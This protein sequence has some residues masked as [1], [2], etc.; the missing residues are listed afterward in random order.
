MALKKKTSYQDC[1][2]LFFTEHR[3]SAQQEADH[4]PP[5]GKPVTSVTP[6]ERKAKRQS[7]LLKDSR[8]LKCRCAAAECLVPLDYLSAHMNWI[9]LYCT[10]LRKEFWGA[11]LCWKL[12]SMWGKRAGRT[13]RTEDL[14][15][16]LYRPPYWDGEGENTWGCGVH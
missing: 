5:D 7:R 10:V 12:C 2:A 11:Y 3:R 9:F 8:G 15:D 16:P 14:L 4:D 6:W 1:D 13:E